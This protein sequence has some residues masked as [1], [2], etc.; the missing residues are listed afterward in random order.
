MHKVIDNVLEDDYYTDIKS[1]LFND[2]VFPWFWGDSQLSA[3]DTFYFYHVFYVNNRP[4][5]PYF[6]VLQPIFNALDVQSLLNVR[7]NLVTNTQGVGFN[8]KHR[9]N[10]TRDCDHKTAIFHLTTNNGKTVLC[11]DDREEEIDTVENRL[12][13]FDASTEHY[14]KHQTDEDRRVLLNINYY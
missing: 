14:S 1:T 9:D 6:D 4:N 8:K 13:M 7:A 3:G 2:K 10:Y 12:L 5:S 11:Y